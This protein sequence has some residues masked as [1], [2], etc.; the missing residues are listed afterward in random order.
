MTTRSFESILPHSAAD[1]YWWHARSGAFER[2]SPPWQSVRM[3]RP[4]PVA[5]GSRA[6]LELGPRWMPLRWVAE[7]L[8]VEPGH[9]F[10]DVQ[11]RGPFR[12][13][14]HRHSFA[15]VSQGVKLRD[16]IDFELPLEP[17]SAPLRGTVSRQ[18]DTL[19]DFRHEATRRDL[20]RHARHPAPPSRNIAVTG[21]SGLVGRHVTPFL[22]TGGHEVAELT[23]GGDSPHWSPTAGLLPGTDLQC[24]TLLH[25]A[26]EN[27][28]ARRWSPSQKERIFA[29]RVEGTRQLVAS[30]RRL[31]NPPTTLVCASAVGIYGS[32]QGEEL[33]ED[34]SPGEGFL[35][36][37]CREW[38]AAAREAEQFGIRVVLLRFGVILTPR[39]GA[40]GRMLPPFRL[41]LGG[42]VGSGDQFLSWVSIDDAVGAV[43]EAIMNRSLAGA[44][45]VV[46]PHPVTSRDFARTLGKVLRRPALAPL[47][48]PVARAAFGEMAEEML[49][50]SQR[51]LPSRLL[52]AGFDFFDH[53]LESA[54]RHLLGRT[55]P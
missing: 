50:A 42:P 54:L 37:L 18:L 51:A 20:A 13:W 31:D 23:R 43:F 5:N 38:E 34:S 32:R 44:F 16:R 1:A 36:Q 49:L 21:A 29:S 12:R 4:A 47:P 28:A 6:V 10:T 27:I 25:L 55:R 30:L 9:G 26:G 46:S 24:D 52:E 8:E 15:D 22:R 53:D 3:V 48:A 19:F 40:L 45:N 14:R 39:G 17:L 7:H 35:A 11:V 2:L 41:G 33:T